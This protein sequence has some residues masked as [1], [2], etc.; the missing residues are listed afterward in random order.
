[1][2]YVHAIYVAPD[3]HKKLAHLKI[4]LEKRSMSETVERIL[5]DWEAW[6]GKIE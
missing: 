3:L 6:Y 4:K 5:N 1:M 2:G